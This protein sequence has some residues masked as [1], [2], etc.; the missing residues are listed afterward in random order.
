MTKKQNPQNKTHTHKTKQN[1][2]R[3]KKKAVEH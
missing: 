3:E 1:T 2:Q